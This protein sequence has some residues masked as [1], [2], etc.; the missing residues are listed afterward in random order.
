ME[1]KVTFTKNGQFHSSEKIT[2]NSHEEAERW[3]Q[4]NCPEGC[5]FRVRNVRAI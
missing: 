1:Y 2:A 4:K 3:A 5:T